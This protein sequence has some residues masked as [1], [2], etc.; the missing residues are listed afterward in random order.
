MSYSICPKHGAASLWGC[1]KC[2]REELRKAVDEE[3][4]RFLAS[5]KKGLRAQQQEGQ[6]A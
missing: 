5:V 2:L 3:C 4:D 1:R 6:K